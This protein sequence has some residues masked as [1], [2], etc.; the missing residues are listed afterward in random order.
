MVKGVEM[1]GRW[2]RR[3]GWIS[4]GE[5]RAAERRVKDGNAEGMEIRGAREKVG[6]WFGRGEMGTRVVVEFATAWA[7]V[8][9]LLPMRL[10]FSV[11]WAE[12]FARAVVLPFGRLFRR[13]GKTG[14]SKAAGTNAVGG[15]GSSSG[16]IS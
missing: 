13:K 14:G 1:F 8:K 6:K 5:E 16:R 11:W 10:M 3:K 7:V 2:F 15:G 12:K 4:E 9:V